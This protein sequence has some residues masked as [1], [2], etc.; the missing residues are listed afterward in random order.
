M[1]TKAALFALLALWGV[2]SAAALPAQARESTADQENVEMEPMRHAFTDRVWQQETETGD[3]PGV[4]RIFLSD[5]T[6]VQDSC[7]ETH[8]LSAWHMTS[9]TGLAWNED[10]AEITAEIVSVDADALVLNLLLGSDT[11][12]EHY[13]AATVPYV[14]PDMPR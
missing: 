8:R 3:R 5:G 7:W 2:G 4:I 6:L 12:E 11:V 13:V 9:D 1:T 10:G 14:C